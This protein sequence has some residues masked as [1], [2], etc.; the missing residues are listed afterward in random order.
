MA[1][2]AGQIVAATLTTKEV[3][4]GSEVGTMLDQVTASVASFTGDGAYDQEG[5]SAA[6]AEHGRAAWQKASG[7]TTR[8]R[9]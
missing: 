7:Y 8:A 3:N 1:A 6:V 5:A 2:D 9:A 4:D